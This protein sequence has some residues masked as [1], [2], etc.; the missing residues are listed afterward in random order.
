MIQAVEEAVIREAR[1][2]DAPFLAWALQE[3][4]RGHVGV[5]SWDI[6]FPGPDA[7]RLA[8][9]EELVREAAGSYVHWSL[10][11]VATVDGVPAASVAGYVPSEMSDNG[12]FEHCCRVMSRRGWPEE[13][14]REAL[15]GARSRD[16]YS[17]PIPEDTL[18]VEW[19]AARPEFRKRGLVRKLLETTLER[20]AARGLAT[21]HVAT[22]LGNEPA[23]SAYRGVGFEFMA[24]VRH[25]DYE[26]KFG[27]P[28]SIYF[29]RSL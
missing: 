19:V 24:E 18:R 2:P 26:S 4:D 9:L 16:Y 1:E 15:A 22:Y 21:A 23:I 14:V 6:A 10:F 29:R 8:I 11:L 28:G 3:S 13:Q 25:V 27:A 17:V 12:F 5:G 20:G 7:E